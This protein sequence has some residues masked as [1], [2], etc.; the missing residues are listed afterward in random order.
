MGLRER[1]GSEEDWTRDEKRGR[2]RWEESAR[3]GWSETER[4]RGKRASE[5]VI[6]RGRQQ[7]GG[8]G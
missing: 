4:E 3:E 8:C 2:E 5:R 6:G 1:Y 7:E